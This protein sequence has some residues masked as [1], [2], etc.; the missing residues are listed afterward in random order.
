[1]EASLDPRECQSAR[2]EE[3]E[4][5]PHPSLLLGAALS[6]APLPSLKGHSISG[7]QAHSHP[8]CH[9]DT[10]HLL[11]C[12]ERET[13]AHHRKGIEEVCLPED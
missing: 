9:L 6:H 8:G 5:G 10:P 3:E 11:P 2:A 7:W 4:K 1:M 13:E 12:T